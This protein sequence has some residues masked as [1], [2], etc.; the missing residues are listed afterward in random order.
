MPVAAGIVDLHGDGFERQILPRP[1]VGVP[2]D[3]A[4]LDT[5]RQMLANG[6]TTAFHGVTY[7]WE[8]G[9]RGADSTRAVVGAIHALRPVLGCDTRVHLRFETHAVDGVD[10]ILEWLLDGLIDLLAFNDHVPHFQNK[11]QRPNGLVG[12]AERA[13]V[14][15]DE[16]AALID[17]AIERADEVPDAVARLATAAHRRGIPT[18]SHDDETPEMRAAF[19]ELGCRISEFPVDAATTQ[20][21]RLS[22][23]IVVLGAPNILRGGSHCGR[24]TALDAIERGL[25]DILTSDYYYPSL[26]HAAYRLSQNGRTGLAAAWNL[27]SAT[28]ARAAGLFDRGEIAVGKRADLILV[29]E[30]DPGL[31]RVLATVVAGK[32]AFIGP[33]TAHRLEALALETCP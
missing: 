33:G 21:A 11:R 31:P 32:P 15:S 2:L 22:G 10:E 23:D 20:A 24:L 7:S 28:P 13:G 18:L 9:L 5:D 19:H 27:V 17:A 12:L 29:G 26:L 16:F 8:P 1:G 25:C 6:I 14:T 4:L 30:E 3:V